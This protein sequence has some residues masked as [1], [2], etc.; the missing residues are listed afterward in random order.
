MLACRL[1]AEE[2]DQY[3]GGTVK[4]PDQRI[5]DAVEP[6]NRLGGE[7][8]DFFSFIDGGGLRSKLPDNDMQECCNE[9]RHYE[10][11]D[12]ACLGADAGPVEERVEQ[13]FK[14]GFRQSTDT[15]RC[16]RDAQ[17]AGG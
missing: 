12:M 8:T 1:H 10:R 3:I 4:Q 2:A 15:Q 6:D 13:L 5:Q 16:N 7:Q 17:L 11:N 9:E 14:S